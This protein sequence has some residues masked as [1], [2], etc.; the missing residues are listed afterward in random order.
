MKPNII[1][2]V[3]QAFTPEDF[4]KLKDRPRGNLRNTRAIKKAASLDLKKDG[5]K[6]RCTKRER[7]PETYSHKTSPMTPS[8]LRLA[9]PSMTSTRS[10]HPQ[11]RPQKR[12]HLE[13]K[14]L[15]YL[16]RLAIEV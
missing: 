1:E 9:F 5:K 4:T 2:V 15:N 13:R 14:S 16:F 11:P 12:P 7:S 3:K 6:A 8:P 10:L